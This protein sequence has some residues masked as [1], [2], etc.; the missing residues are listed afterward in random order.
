VVGKKRGELVLHSRAPNGVSK[1]GAVGPRYGRQ[2]SNLESDGLSK[3]SLSPRSHG[4]LIGHRNDGNCSS[5]KADRSSGSRCHR[6]R[7]RYWGSCWSS[8]R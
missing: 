2:G 3:A 6:R 4:M 7:R 1:R 8:W 5:R